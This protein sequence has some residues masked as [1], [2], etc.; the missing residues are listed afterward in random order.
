MTFLTIISSS[1]R[2]EL[3]ATMPLSTSAIW[4]NCSTYGN[5]FIKSRKHRLP[6][7]FG[8]IGDRHWRGYDFV[9]IGILVASQEY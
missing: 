8:Q 3:D 1:C 4:L 7:S 2:L 9:A 6:A 5:C